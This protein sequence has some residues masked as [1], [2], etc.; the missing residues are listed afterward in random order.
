MDVK[1]LV[2]EA[3]CEQ[4]GVSADRILPEVDFYSDLGGDSLDF[5][6]LIMYFEEEMDFEIEDK[7]V[8][9]L[10]TVKEFTDYLEKRNN[11][12]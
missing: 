3:L 6:E 5:V 8:E 7:D 9:K 1:K 10:R 11:S 4:L 12:T 2:S